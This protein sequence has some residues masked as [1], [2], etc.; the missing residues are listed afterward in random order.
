MRPEDSEGVLRW[1]HKKIIR[2]RG[3]RSSCLGP[4][5]LAAA[6]CA[7]LLQAGCQV[8][9]GG[10]QRQLVSH[11]RIQGAVELDAELTPSILFFILSL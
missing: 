2:G 4:A 8:T 5:G 7:L 10:K 3:L 6:L 9:V 11:E 1:F